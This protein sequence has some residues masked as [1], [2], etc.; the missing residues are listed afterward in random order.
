MFVNNGDPDGMHEPSCRAKADEQP[1][2]ADKSTQQIEDIL[3][4]FHLKRRRAAWRQ[5]ILFGWLLVTVG[6]VL[7][8]IFLR[9]Q[10]FS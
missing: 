4:H 6:A 8:T 5:W 3:E 1:S 2:A 7:L 9:Y 10:N